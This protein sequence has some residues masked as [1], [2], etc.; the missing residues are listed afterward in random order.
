MLVTEKFESNYVK[1][2]QE[3]CE[4]IFFLRTARNNH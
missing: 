4:E 2:N 1:L 3:R